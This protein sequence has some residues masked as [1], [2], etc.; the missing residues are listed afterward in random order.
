MPKDPGERILANLMKHM[1]NSEHDP[2][3][4]LLDT[5]FIQRGSSP[6]RVREHVINMEDRPRPEGRLSPSTLCGCERQAAFKFVDMP[7][8]SVIDPETE[9]I[10]DDGKWRHHKWQATFRDME[11][12]LGRK[13]FRLLS[14]EEDVE[15]PDLYI[16]GALDA[17]IAIERKLWV[18]D[19]KGINSWGFEYVYRENAPH[20]THVKQLLAYMVSRRVRRGMILYDHK[21]RSKTKIF[22]IKFSNK[23][24]AEVVEWSEKVLAQIEREELPPMSINCQAGNFLFEK[25]A[26]THICYGNKSNE[27]IRRRMY[28]DFESIED[29]W[30]RGSTILA[31]HAEGTAV[32][33][34]KRKAKVS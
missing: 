3:T 14:Y 23:Q 15:Y 34:R 19:F 11:M 25:C 24:W 33:I 2:L 17:L 20:E 32:K 4:P 28:R 30:E 27:Q 18:V 6:R 1:E 31:D 29:S 16:A 5:Y 8:R 7:G 26:W 22:V 12:V 10:F 21:D 13:T 9:A